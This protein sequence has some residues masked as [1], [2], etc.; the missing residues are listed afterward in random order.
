M[1]MSHQHPFGLEQGLDAAL[2]L[3]DRQVVDS[4]GRLACKVDDVELTERDGTVVVTGL[5]VG[6]SALLPRIGGGSLARLW[7]LTS[8]ARAGRE[9]PGWVDIA[10]VVEVDS[11]VRLRRGRE[12]VVR[13]Q[14]AASDDV[15]RHRLDDLLGLE[16][17]DAEG[18]SL[19]SVLDVRLRAGG[20]HEGRLV[21][22]HLVVGKDRAGV[23]LG[24]DRG[25][26]AGPAVLCALLRWVHRHSVLVPLE[27]SRI[28]RV[29]GTVHVRRPAG[30][31]RGLRDVGQDGSHG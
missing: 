19:G 25:A 26:V 27:E 6:P 30:P 21:A 14:P 16:V 15:V 23:R 22:S 2:H 1:T 29:T 8:V 17:S 28:D 11:A 31:L 13:P 12:G 18:R 4:D 7:A 20:P 10:D 24:Y 3:L 5:L 9:V